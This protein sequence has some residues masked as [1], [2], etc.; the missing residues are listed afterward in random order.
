[1]TVDAETVHRL[2]A[3]VDLLPSIVSRSTGRYGAVA[4]HLPGA[5]VEG[6][7]HSEDGRWEV[8]VVMTFDSTVSAVE[9]DVLAAAHSVGL[10]GPVDVFIE[11][12]ADRPSP[13]HAADA[14]AQILPPG[15][16]A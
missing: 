12:I 16:L 8:H 11:D 14:S 3:A 1:M 6:N 4:A 2:A 13:Q 9:A 7:R 15:S 5:R 10:T